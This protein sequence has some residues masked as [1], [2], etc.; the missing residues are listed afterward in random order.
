MTHTILAAVSFAFF[1]I[2]ILRWHQRAPMFNR[3]PFNCVPCLSAWTGLLLLLLPS[4]LS[5]IVLTI[6]GSGVLGAVF[7]QIM[8]NIYKP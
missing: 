8:F 2:E 7:L 5:E 1:L 4:Q 6:F 3:K